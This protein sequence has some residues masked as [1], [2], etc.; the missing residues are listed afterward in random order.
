MTREEKLYAMRM[1]ELVE[2]AEAEGIKIDKKGSKQKAVEKILVYEAANAEMRQE[3]HEARTE[4]FQTE[5]QEPETVHIDITLESKELEEKTEAEKEPEEKKKRKPRKKKEMSEDVSNILDYVF[6]TWAADF[7]IVRKNESGGKFAALCIG[8][9]RQVIKVM[10]TCEKVILFNRC[11]E[12]L[13]YS[14]EI[15]TYDS[16]GLPYACMFR[17][18]DFQTKA[19]IRF[20]FKIASINDTIR[21]K[22]I[23]KTA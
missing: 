17:G 18:Y 8:G 16:Y 6:N 22:R 9:G 5:A 21:R 13:N 15:R 23:K 2:V 1:T 3:E 11:K 14:T 19:D 10:W 20:I 4:T 7:G 12:T